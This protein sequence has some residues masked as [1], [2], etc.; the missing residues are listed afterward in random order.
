MTELWEEKENWSVKW[1]ISIR[2]SL[3][4][5]I[6]WNSIWKSQCEKSKWHI[7]IDRAIQSC[8]Y[9]NSSV[10]KSNNNSFKKTQ[11]KMSKTLNSESDQQNEKVHIENMSSFPAEKLIDHNELNTK[12]QCC[13]M[14]CWKLF[15]HCDIYA[16][17]ENEKE[18][19]N[20]KIC[21]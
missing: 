16:A 3:I 19:K 13:K 10:R 8:L 15:S 7:Y 2:K 12:Q 11:V 9:A 1:T 20:S 5:L 14:W 6:K 18:Y 4:K 17:V 21:I